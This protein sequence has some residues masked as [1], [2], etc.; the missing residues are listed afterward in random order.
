MKYDFDKVVDRTENFAAK[1]DELGKKFGKENLIPLWVADMD[2]K[3]AEP[4]TKAIQERAAQGIFGYTSRPDSY[5]QSIEQ[6]LERRHGWKN[7]PKLMVH[8]PGVVPSLCLLIQ[9]FTE[10]GDKIIIQSPVYY[11]FFDV[12]RSNGRTLV[13]NPLKIVEGRYEMDFENLEEVAKNGA[14]LLIL[15]S[16]HNPIGR[17]WKKEELIRLGDI[18]LAYGVRIIADEI[19]SD[20]VFSGHKHT[21][22]AM[23]S[24]EFRKNTF[25]C[26]APSKTFNLAGL[27]ASVTI[28]PTAE[29]RDKFE[30]TLGDLDIKRNN[31]F[32]LVATE[33]AYR[34]GEEWLE[35]VKE[36]IEGNFAYVQD[37]CKKNIPLI[38][39]NFPEGTY[40][41]WFD[42]R[43]LGMDKDELH[44][45]M[46]DEAGI[47]MDDGF[48][49]SDEYA[50]Y[51][52]MNVACPRSIIAKALEQ[53]KNAI[54]KRI[55]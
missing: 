45:F 24:E 6:W 34:H 10:P 33:A 27:Q 49:F 36:Y 31:C 8:C 21:P 18:C 39:P 54:E 25:S 23:I 19:H 29:D 55:R 15:C 43:Q 32:S 16:P 38:Q 12:V 13:E 4:I 26:I 28:F 1:Y 30:G 9:N 17:V 2:F 41:V 42:C 3:V 20:L 37:Y 22:F 46:L 47:A 48:W 35:Q 5:F 40:L 51:M 50:G 53:W 52:R 14:K 7:D 11:P 44:N